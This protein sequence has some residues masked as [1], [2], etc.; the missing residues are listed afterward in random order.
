MRIVE[1][2]RRRCMHGHVELVAMQFDRD[3]MK[4][5]SSFL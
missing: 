3:S 2:G 4:K 1:D 5:C